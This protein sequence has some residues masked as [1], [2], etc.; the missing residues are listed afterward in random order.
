MDTIFGSPAAAGTGM[1]WQPEATDMVVSKRSAAHEKAHLSKEEL[2]FKVAARR[3]RLLGLWVAD[4]L[5]LSGEAAAAYAREVVV[6][7]LDEPGDADIVRKV[8]GD[9]AAKGI[10]VSAK[11]IG[12][13]MQAL[14]AE[15][16]A[17][18]TQETQ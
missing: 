16:R 10:D 8:A 3:N 14:L 4:K 5:G 6:A 11:E 13:R 17:Q 18:I 1:V 15:A 2:A 9:L 7:D 12:E